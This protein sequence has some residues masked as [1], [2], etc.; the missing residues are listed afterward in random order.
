M[1]PSTLISTFNALARNKLSRSGTVPNHWHIS[2]HNVPL[3]PPDE[4]PFIIN[5]G[6][7]YVHTAGPLPQTAKNVSTAVKAR[8]L[9]M[10]LLKAFNE[11]IQ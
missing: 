8:A 3:Q 1:D 2:V 9:G 4:I 6:S 10:V 5:P 7:R 11:G